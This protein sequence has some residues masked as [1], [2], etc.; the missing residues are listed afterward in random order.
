[1][2]ALTF[3]SLGDEPL[4]VVHVLRVF[5]LGVA[6][7]VPEVDETQNPPDV[8]RT[9][10]T[11]GGGQGGRGDT[12]QPLWTTKMGGLLYSALTQYS[13]FLRSRSSCWPNFRLSLMSWKLSAAP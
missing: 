13:S 4:Q 1:M 8:C 9:D 7:D 10:E 12:Y 5:G 2:S 11:G 6:Q 3:Q